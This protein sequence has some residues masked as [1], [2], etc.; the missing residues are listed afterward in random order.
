MKDGPVFETGTVC[1]G[2]MSDKKRLSSFASL[3][4]KNLLFLH[5]AAGFGQNILNDLD[6]LGSIMMSF[7]FELPRPPPR[8]WQKRRLFISHAIG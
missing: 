5:L 3:D 8:G 7:D 4:L 6:L 2:R 1:L